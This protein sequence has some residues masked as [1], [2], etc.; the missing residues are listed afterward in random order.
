VRQGREERERRGEP[1]VQ[2]LDMMVVISC[3]FV[4]I[5][6]FLKKYMIHAL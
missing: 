2:L 4:C 3:K 6:A 1:R 5:P